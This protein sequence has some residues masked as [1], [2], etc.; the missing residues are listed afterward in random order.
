MKVW[1]GIL[2]VVLAAVMATGGY[3]LGAKMEQ[4]NIT[5]AIPK[6]SMELEEPQMHV[7][8]EVSETDSSA[9]GETWSKLDESAYSAEGLNGT[10]TLSTSAETYEGELI[11]DDGQYWVLEVSDGNGGYYTLLNDYISNGSVYFEIL[12]NTDGDRVIN[13]Y[14]ISGAGVSIKQYSYYDGTFT[15]IPLYESGAVNRLYSSVP[16]YN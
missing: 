10:I 2:V 1:K 9:V 4:R 14:I 11:W 12:E 13:A 15:Q 16:N 5:T 7:A 8:V 6:Q 3:T